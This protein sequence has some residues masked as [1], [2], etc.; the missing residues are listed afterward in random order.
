MK[1]GI[2]GLGLMGASFAKA[3]KRYTSHT[4][5]GLDRDP[6]V[7]ESALHDGA[8]DEVHEDPAFLSQCAV[9]FLCL[10]PVQT[11]AFVKENLSHFQKGSI[12]ADICGIKGYVVNALSQMELPF[13]Y[14]PSHPMAGREVCGYH[15]SLESLFVGAS[16]ICTPVDAPQYAV[17][18]LESLVRSIGFTDFVVTTPA[19]HDR[20]IAFTSQLPHV[21]SN[22]YVKSPSCSKHNGFSAGS[23]KDLSRVAKLNEEMWSDL[24]LLNRESLLS[25]LDTLLQ[26][27][28]QYRDALAREDRDALRD[29]LREGRIIKE[30]CDQ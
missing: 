28:A 25:E 19:D 4:V 6:A 11:V 20:I 22:A 14:L 27:L 17:D 23:Y 3:L 15:G 13:I 30:E 9:T 26:N 1:I 16:Y 2:V 12:V 18:T 5:L 21:I 7:R 10:F 24:F 8:V 29:L